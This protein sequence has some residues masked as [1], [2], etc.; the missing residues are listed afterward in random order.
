M[1]RFLLSAWLAYRALF[2]WL[3]PAGYI[4]TRLVSPIA[5][6]MIFSGVAFAAGA[7][8][9]RPA[10]GGP[11][12][13]A[14]M[15]GVFG[16]T[17]AVGNERSFGTL[18]LWLMA[19]RGLV[20]S[21]VSKAAGHIADGLLGAVVTAVV[22]VAAFA[23]PVHPGQ[24][25]LLLAA[26]LAAA[27]SGAGLGM[28]CAAAALRF[29]NQFTAPNL[30]SLVIMLCA[31]VFIRPGKLGPV[32]SAVSPALPGGHATAAALDAIGGVA[33]AWTQLAIEVGVG[34]AWGTIGVVLVRLALRA[35]RRAG[36][37]ELT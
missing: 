37:L 31:G 14:T 16:V 10:L 29:R 19:P 24:V 11:L 32:V 18:S 25:V 2:T 36:T 6:A 22:L 4:S 5:L 20:A 34:V 8:R 12:L 27:V 21:L 26:A 7:D 9:A 28:V 13:A 35:A 23:I 30:A 33:G 17:L 3:N 15:A 1:R